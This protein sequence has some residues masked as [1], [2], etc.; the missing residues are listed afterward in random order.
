MS[1]CCTL[2]Y[3]ETLEHSSYLDNS[4]SRLF[5]VSLLVGDKLWHCYVRDL[6]IECSLF[7]FCGDKPIGGRRKLPTLKEPL[8]KYAR[9]EVWSVVLE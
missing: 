3:S 8:T 4:V 5:P 6:A 7:I 1:L 9:L 2:N